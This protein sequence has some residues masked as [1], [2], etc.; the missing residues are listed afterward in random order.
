MKL[1]DVL[2]S[3]QLLLSEKRGDNDEW[4]KSI[5]KMDKRVVLGL[6]KTSVATIIQAGVSIPRNFKWN[7]LIFFS[8]YPRAYATRYHRHAMIWDNQYHLGRGMRMWVLYFFPPT[9]PPLNYL[10]FFWVV[11]AN[12]FRN[13]WV[14]LFVWVGGHS[15]VTLRGWVSSTPAH[16]TTWYLMKFVLGLVVLQPLSRGS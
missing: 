2:K 11:D 13:Y 10:V 1:Q 4:G 9:N 5:W 14:W 8:D 7:L 3:S 15:L 16:D 12:I 6:L